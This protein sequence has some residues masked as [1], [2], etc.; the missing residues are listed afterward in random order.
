MRQ[1]RA[2]R[3]TCS[4]PTRQSAAAHPP[5]AEPLH[6]QPLLWSFETCTPVSRV[7]GQSMHAHQL[8]AAAPGL[9]PRSWGTRTQTNARCTGRHTQQPQKQS[10]RER[11][12]TTGK[13]VGPEEIGH[14]V[15]DG[16]GRPREVD[17]VDTS[18]DDAA[19]CCRRS[20]EHVLHKRQQ[21]ET[22]GLITKK[23]HTCAVVI[24]SLKTAE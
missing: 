10:P 8:P 14:A 23:K 18:G 4:W 9:C 13:R 7:G 19:E 16:H 17:D 15:R 2:L 20:S 11:R 12:C 22:Q 24:R 5:T 21:R 1:P 6:P 3:I